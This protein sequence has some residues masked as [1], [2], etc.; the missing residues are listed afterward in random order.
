VLGFSNC[1]WAQ[2]RDFLLFNLA[3]DEDNIVAPENMRDKN[4]APNVLTSIRRGAAF[5]FSRAFQRPV[6]RQA[7][8]ASRQRRLNVRGVFIQAS[9]TRRRARLVIFPGLERP[10]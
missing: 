7:E 5:E 2:S 8:P 10:G 4:V 9:L 3:D 1:F 6:T